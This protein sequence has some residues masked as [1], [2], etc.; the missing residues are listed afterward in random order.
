MAVTKPKILHL[1]Q[2]S[3]PGGAESI[4]LN[5]QKYYQE[6]SGKYEHSCGLISKGWLD[7]ELCRTGI[8]VIFVESGKRLDLKLIKNL[9]NIVKKRD[10]KIIHSHLCDINFYSSFV[11]KLARIK[12]VSTE[13]GDIHHFSKSVLKQYIKYIFIS[14]FSDKIVCVSN[15]TRKKLIKKNP[16]AKN[17][18]IVIYN[19]IPIDNQEKSG[20][21]SLRT[22]THINIINVANLY[23]VKGQEFLIRAIKIVLNRYPETK[24]SIIGRGQLE[25]KLKE[26]AITLGLENSIQFM[27]FREDVRDLLTS[28]DIFVISSVSEGFPVSVI[29]AMEA[30]L[31]IV[32]TEV[33]GI[34]ELKKYGVFIKFARAEDPNDLAAKI[35]SMIEER[36]HFENNNRNIAAQNFSVQAMAKK[37]INLYDD[38]TGANF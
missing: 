24:L 21:R 37:Y 38:L 34:T 20:S 5:L 31:P 8:D 2:T 35:I 32:S 13:H 12:H 23:P 11:A 19:G 6:R 16:W 10:I 9:F 25:P 18:S 30:G 33:G 15:Y 36:A 17:K 4:F 28:F 7:N 1:I 26:L 22:K 29:E 14:L 27:G 3:G